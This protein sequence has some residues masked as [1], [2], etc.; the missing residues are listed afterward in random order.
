MYIVFRFIGFLISNKR[1]EIRCNMS[2]NF[3][4]G[5]IHRAFIS[6]GFNEA[7]LSELKFVIDGR[8]SNDLNK[9]YHIAQ[10]EE[11]VIV[12][13]PN[14]IPVIK[15]KLAE[16]FVKHGSEMTNDNITTCNENVTMTMLESKQERETMN[17]KGSLLNQNS[18][19]F[20]ET[21]PSSESPKPLTE[22]KIEQPKMTKEVIDMMN[23]KT[24]KLFADDDFKSLLRI[25]MRRPELFNTL[26]LFVQNN[27][28]VEETISRTTL[29]EE[30][31]KDLDN[32]MN[33]L[34]QLG[35][36][37]SDEKLKEKVIKYNGHL[38]LILRSILIDKLF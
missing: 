14:N 37:I 28:L 1:Y 35:L 33:E 16:I 21:M 10:T 7:A 5:D 17:C 31:T 4:L 34:K 25:Y 3:K 15:N 27:D 24:V 22:V 2:G 32:N 12:I 38:N 8:I 26:S 36:V 23:K 6:M 20:N 9:E 11:K 13:I 29:T 18:E 30:E 19:N